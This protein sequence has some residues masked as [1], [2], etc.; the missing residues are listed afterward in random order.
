MKPTKDAKCEAVFTFLKDTKDGKYAK[1]DPKIVETPRI[2][3]SRNQ[4][5]IDEEMPILFSITNKL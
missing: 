3:T 1:I 5:L 4:Y 2:M